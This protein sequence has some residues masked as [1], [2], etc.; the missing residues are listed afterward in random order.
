MP[1]TATF[2][3]DI[4]KDIGDVAQCVCYC[5]GIEQYLRDD[6]EVDLFSDDIDFAL[7]V[8]DGTQPLEEFTEELLNHNEILVIGSKL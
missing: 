1:I 7:L 8:D 5:D 2:E 6:G 4:R 3:D